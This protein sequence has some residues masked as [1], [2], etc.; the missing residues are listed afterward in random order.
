MVIQSCKSP[1]D[2]WKRK[3]IK[4]FTL[5]EIIVAFTILALVMVT[6]SGLFI[7]VNQA[8]QRQRQ[9]IDLVQNARWAVEFMVREIRQG[10]NVSVDLEFWGGES[11]F[12]LQFEL[13]PGGSDNRVRYF[14]GN[15]AGFG[16]TNVLYRKSGAG[17]GP[18]ADRQE[19]ANFIVDNPNGNPIFSLVGGVLTIELTVRPRPQDPEGRGNR[20]YTVRTQVRP[21]N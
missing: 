19:L 15:G 12:R 11:V 4:G 3:K 18:P 10:R 8:W 16:P 13:P 1:E 7:S 9:T 14:R 5:P 20:N 21:R 17:L 6:A 2:H